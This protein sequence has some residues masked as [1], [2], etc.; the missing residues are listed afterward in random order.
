MTTR[1]RIGS[2]M[3]YIN[4]DNVSVAFTLYS[5]SVHRRR[6]LQ[7]NHTGA[8]IEYSKRGVPT[9]KALNDIT[10]SFSAGDRVGLL[11]G[12]G[13]GK[14]TLLRVIAGIYPP[15]KGAL[16]L[17]GYIGSLIDIDLGIDD[18]STGKENYFVRGTML[19]FSRAQLNSAFE[20]AVDFS[21]LADYIDLPVSTYS[22]GMRFRLAFA[23]ATLGQPDILLLD[24][25]LSVSDEVFK[26]KVEK[27]LTQII[28]KSDILIHANHS[29]QTLEETC[30]RFVIL[31]EGYVV[32]DSRSTDILDEYFNT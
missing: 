11:G 2:D 19:G 8:K 17:N 23:V 18:D 4:I 6:R 12:N 9:I 27:R 31:H 32:G 24:E 10:L 14:S 28:E 7:Q 30:N 13:A 16:S 1:L 21:G 3:S 25:W 20:E 15:I 26:L 22:S 29:R 5:H